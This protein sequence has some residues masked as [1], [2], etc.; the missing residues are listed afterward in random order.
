MFQSKDGKRFGSAFVAK[1]RDAEHDKSAEPTSVE[2]VKAPVAENSVGEQEEQGAHEPT[3]VVAQH[4]K[5]HTVHIA[6]DHKNKK[7]HV[8]S[9]HED[10]HVHESEH[11]SPKEAH[12]AASV[13]ASAAGDQPSPDATTGVEKAPESDGFSMPKLA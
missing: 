5:A 4:G 10:G 13:L 1:R 3:Q 7:H 8:I 12:D 11:G 9:T 6:H 2:E